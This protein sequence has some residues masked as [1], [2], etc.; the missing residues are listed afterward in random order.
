MGK[1][2]KEKGGRRKKGWGVEVNKQKVNSQEGMV[3]DKLEETRQ[4]SEAMV[5]T[6]LRANPNNLLDGGVVDAE[7][8]GEGDVCCSVSNVS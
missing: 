8:D 2:K 5:P 6:A 7:E 1:K 3:T 4:Y